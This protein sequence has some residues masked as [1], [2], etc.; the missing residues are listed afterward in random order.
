MAAGGNADAPAAPYVP[1]QPIVTLRCAC[2]IEQADEMLYWCKYCVELRC[3]S[4]V[5]QEIDSFFDTNFADDMP[6]PEEATTAKNR[7]TAGTIDCPVCPCPLTFEP[8][9]TEEGKMFL[10]CGHCLWSSIEP[11]SVGI[12]GTAEE[13]KAQISAHME[14]PFTKMYGELVEQYQIVAK[15]EMRALEAKRSSA[16]QLTQRRVTSRGLY[17]RYTYRREGQQ[18]TKAQFR[19][20][21]EQ[22]RGKVW[23]AAKTDWVDEPD[24]SK[25]VALAAKSARDIPALDPAMFEGATSIDHFA[26]IDQRFCVLASQPATI[27][28]AFPTQHRLLGKRSKR[29]R[30]CQHNL[31]KP[32]ASA[33]SIRYRMQLFASLHTP[34]VRVAEVSKLAH[35]TEGYVVLRI[36]NPVDQDLEITLAPAMPPDERRAA[37]AAAKE[38]DA[39][40]KKEAE[41]AGGA[42]AAAAAAASLRSTAKDKD[43]AEYKIPP[44]TVDVRLRPTI[45]STASVKLPEKPLK[46]AAHDAVQADS[47]DVQPPNPDDDPVVIRRQGNA[48]VIK[49]AIVPNEDATN[50]VV[51]EFDMRYT[52]KVVSTAFRTSQA[53]SDKKPQEHMA[54][55]PV[56]VNLG[57]LS[58]K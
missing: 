1:P 25:R 30:E 36:S 51:I 3:R 10:Q 23:D 13:I 12:S 15:E 52:Y 4:C 21:E 14:G 58:A 41:A 47:A 55:I 56:Q 33:M 53:T 35:A 32:D 26:S 8:M 16:M 5:S 43:S 20:K 11:G 17:T 42:A 40:A 19:E 28:A 27:G 48:I 7:S 38:A 2:G 39:K 9:A 18:I 50:D 54:S 49:L 57:A 44:Q 6:S 24:T 37:K 45:R 29:C 22:R 31:I 34:Q 46:F